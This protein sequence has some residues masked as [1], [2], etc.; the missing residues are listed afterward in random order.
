MYF[1]GFVRITPL[2]RNGE[3]GL[4]SS[5]YLGNEVEVPDTGLSFLFRNPN[6]LLTEITP[7]WRHR[8]PEEKD[9]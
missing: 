5:H 1:L 3:N 7:C 8:F 9:K 4:Q 2:M 6:V